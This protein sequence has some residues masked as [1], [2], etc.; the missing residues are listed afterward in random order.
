M[1]LFLF[2]FTDP[3][4]HTWRSALIA[5]PDRAVAVALMGFGLDQDQ[6]LSEPG[7]LCAFAGKAEGESRLVRRI[8]WDGAV[9]E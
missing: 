3:D 1:R 2:T 5:A 9:E 8:G 6:K 4:R 7:V